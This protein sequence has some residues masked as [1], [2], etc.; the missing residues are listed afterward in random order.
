MLFRS[1]KIIKTNIWGISNY[2]AQQKLDQLT[3]GGIEEN[4]NIS[5]TCYDSVIESYSYDIKDYVYFNL[6]VY[7]T[8]PYF[9]VTAEEMQNIISVI[10]RCSHLDRL[11]DESSNLIL[12]QKCDKIVALFHKFMLQLF[13]EQSKYMLS[14]LVKRFVQQNIASFEI[15][16]LEHGTL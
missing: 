11:L 4:S 6:L 15:L 9:T 12:N 16:R 8:K 1:L 2:H 5:E 7:A 14:T 10:D 13:K 3:V